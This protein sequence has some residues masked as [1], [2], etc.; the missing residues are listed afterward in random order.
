MVRLR[1]PNR[2]PSALSNRRTGT[3]PSK[4][5]IWRSQNDPADPIDP[6][7]PEYVDEYITARIPERPVEGDAR[8]AQKLHYYNMVT[9]LYV[10]DCEDNENAC[11][12]LAS[13]T[14][15]VGSATRSNSPATPP[16]TRIVAANP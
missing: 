16:L 5:W 1:I 15:S 12:G 9:S 10:H 14:I 4:W 13:R 11:V 6:N 2:L 8:Y 3:T 7:T